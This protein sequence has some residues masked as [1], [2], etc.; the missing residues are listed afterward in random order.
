VEL[1]HGGGRLLEGECAAV[2]HAP[3]RGGERGVEHRTDVEHLAV[4]GLERAS[5]SRAHTA[6][7]A[8][9]PLTI[10]QRSSACGCL[11]RRDTSAWRRRC[12]DKRARDPHTATPTARA[13]EERDP[14]HPDEHISLKTAKAII[15]WDR[16]VAGSEAPY[17]VGV[18][19][20]PDGTTTMFFGIITPP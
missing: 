11:G 19:Q 4:M 7:C 1:G 5:R 14:A 10:R 17:V 15:Y 18:Q 3:G 16:H 8:R 20:N 2:D 12:R 9:Q 13:R 6:A